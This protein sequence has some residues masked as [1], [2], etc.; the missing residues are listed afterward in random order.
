MKDFTCMLT[1]PLLPKRLRSFSFNKSL[2]LGHHLLK[3]LKRHSSLLRP[4]LLRRV[5]ETISQTKL[6][7]VVRL[8][9][10][11]DAFAVKESLLE[12]KIVLV[13][14]FMTTGS[15]LNVAVRKLKKAGAERI[16]L[17]GSS[18]GSFLMKHLNNP[19]PSSS[20]LKA[21]SAPA[22]VIFGSQSYVL[23]FLE[24]FF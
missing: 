9:N 5:R 3:N 10:P 22:L 13:N 1:I 16:S 12:G 8:R 6:H 2:L 18:A 15:T 14:D 4:S 20:D 11:Y 17:P 23:E 24:H 7:Y 19:I 21:S